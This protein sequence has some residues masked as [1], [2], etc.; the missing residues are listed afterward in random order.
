MGRRD[1][2]VDE[3]IGRAPA[4][5]RPI[6]EHLREVV[7]SADPEIEETLKWKMPYFVDHG[8][9]CGMA[10]FKEHCTFAFWNAEVL[11]EALDTAAQGAAMGQFGRLRSLDDL[12]PDDV[13]RG[14]VREAVKLNRAGKKP[15]RAA[16]SSGAVQIP[17]LQAALADHPSAREVFERFSPSHRREYVEWITEAKREETRAR[18]IAQ[19]VEW[20]AEGKP[21]NWK[22]M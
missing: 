16:A 5:A 2:R 4:F 18:R 10:A 20:I 9:V 12:P 3:Y 22:Y 15:R 7:H 1:Q 6:L 11:G 17:P 14:Y 8:M 21:R 19:A 13:L